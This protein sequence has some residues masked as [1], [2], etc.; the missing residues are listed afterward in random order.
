MNNLNQFFGLDVHMGMPVKP[1]V[2]PTYR[3]I[4]KWSSA[5]HFCLHKKVIFSAEDNGVLSFAEQQQ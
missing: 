4:T 3:F 2:W 1:Y 5:E